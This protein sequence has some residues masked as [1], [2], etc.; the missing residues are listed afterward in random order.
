M[1]RRSSSNHLSPCRPDSSA[2]WPRRAPTAAKSSSGLMRHC[3][4]AA[5]TILPRPLGQ[6]LSAHGLPR[7]RPA[8]S[9]RQAGWSLL[10]VRGGAAGPRRR[11]R[12]PLSGWR[13]R[14]HL[15]APA[16]DT[17]ADTSSATRTPPGR[18][19]PARARAGDAPAARAPA[20]RET[21]PLPPLPPVRGASARRAVWQRRN[22]RARR[23]ARRREAR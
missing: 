13:H 20:G 10:A 22:R 12:A 4:T 21:A 6:P 5:A 7:C 11:G 14:A 17:E 15:A 3:A 9:R 18:F 8:P 23:S 2:K 16:G 1:K 19:R